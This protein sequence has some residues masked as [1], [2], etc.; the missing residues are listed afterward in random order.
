MDK[1]R[2][3]KFVLGM[4]MANCYLLWKENHVL[5][6]DPGSTSR[7]LLNYLQEKEAIVDGIL[8]THAHFDHIGGVD[9]FA[10]HFHCPVYV[11][12]DDEKMLTNRN[13]NCSLPGREVIVQSSVNNYAAGM[14]KLGIF[15]FEVHYAPGHTHGSVL[16]QFD[17]ILF[18]GDVLFKE[19]IGRTD[20]PLG[21]NAEMVNTLNYIKTLNPDL[22]VF[23][24]HGDATTIGFELLHNPYL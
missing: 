15:D 2:V 17:D 13:L 1:Y 21:S 3:E 12:A 9:Y 19:S 5:I 22:L 6:V 20:L 11:E 16:L 23:P 14:N 24:G 7:K 10:S 18:S 4:Y 8:L